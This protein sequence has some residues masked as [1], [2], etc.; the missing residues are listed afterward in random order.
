MSMSLS[1][2]PPPPPLP[3]FRFE[4]VR[5]TDLAHKIDSITLPQ[6]IVPKSSFKLKQF[7]WSKIP[8]NRI[9][10]KDNIWTK[11]AVQSDIVAFDAEFYSYLEQYFV[12]AKKID[13]RRHSTLIREFKLMHSSDKINLLDGFKDLHF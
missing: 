2:P 1:I 11:Y 9:A 4:L 7:T 12:E 8:L 13:D 3:D 10:G 5:K 6:Q